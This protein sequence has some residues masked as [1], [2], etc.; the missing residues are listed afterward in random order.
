MLNVDMPIKVG[1]IPSA[2][3][4]IKMFRGIKTIYIL[5]CCRRGQKTFP[6]LC[7]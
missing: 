1:L 5:F 4:P 7:C 6:D 2:I 3:L